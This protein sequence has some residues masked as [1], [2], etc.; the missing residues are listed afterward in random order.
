MTAADNCEELL[1]RK[2]KHEK[3]FLMIDKVPLQ[4]GEHGLSMKARGLLC[5]LYSL[6]DGWKFSVAGLTKIFPD[7]KDAIKS[8]IKELEDAN[9]LKRTQTRDS[10]GRMSASNWV[11]CDIPMS[12]DSPMTE[13]PPTVN[14]PQYNTKECRTNRYK[15]TIGQAQQSRFE[16]VWS[17][18]PNKKGRE[19][20]RKAY[21]KAL[22][23]GCSH[24]D[25]LAG[26][27]AYACY[28]Q[29]NG[30]DPKFIKHGS[31]FF[32]QRSWQD[33]WTVS[34]ATNGYGVDMSYEG[35]GDWA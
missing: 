9:Y 27:Q 5:T 19:T 16:E 8:A 31:T 24:E 12:D 2:R 26:T 35:W 10:S 28:V 7:G 17:I 18:Y 15:E 32:N 4:S 34:Q 6:P 30:T 3:N 13:N 1:S 14:P 33:D 21:E 25:I 29:A 20:A 23:D 11:V 22:K